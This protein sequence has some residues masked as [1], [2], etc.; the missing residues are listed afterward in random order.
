[1]AIKAFAYLRTSSAANVG[2]DKDSDTRQFL[3]INTYAVAN[4]IELA[5]KFYDAAVSGADPLEA[6][7]GFAAMIARI[8]GNGVRMVI[9]EDAS[10][11]ARDVMVQELGIV[12]MR[13]IGVRVVTAT[14]LDLTA[15]S[16]DSDFMRVVFGAFS[17]LEK[18]RLVAKMRGARDRKSEALGRRIEG[19]KGFRKAVPELIYGAVQEAVRQF[20]NASLAGITA[21]MNEAGLRTKTGGMIT[22][23]QVAR[24]IDAMGLPKIDGRR[25]VTA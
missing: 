21:E 15:V 8:A 10:R 25:K 5:D 3:A 2:S 23:T 18:G 19:A 7:K 12:W 1:M 22:A 6:R 20:P 11:F 4:G 16:A 14:G 24:I 9:V 13:S 17:A